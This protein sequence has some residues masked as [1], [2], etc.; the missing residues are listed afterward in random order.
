[1]EKGRRA[2]RDIS[3]CLF[4]SV[5]LDK[6]DRINEAEFSIPQQAYGLTAEQAKETF[7]RLDVEKKGY[8]QKSTYVDR[9]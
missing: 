6:D 3:L 8:W 1:M 2:E 4:D 5:D 9:G 7:E